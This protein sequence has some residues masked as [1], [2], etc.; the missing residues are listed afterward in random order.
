[1]IEIGLW[2]NWMALA[3]MTPALWAVSSI[4]DICF[5]GERIFRFPSDGPIISGLFGLL[6]LAVLGVQIG[7]WDT[8]P[9][10]SSAPAVLAGIC[11]FLHMYFVFKA[12]FLFNDGSCSEIF[13]LLSVLFVPFLAFLVLGEQLASMHYLAISLAFGGIMALIRGYVF[14]RN[15][16]VVL[17]LMMSVLC[18]SMAMVIQAWVF[19]QMPYWN[20][21]VLF[22]FGSLLTALML[23]C[24][25]PDRC[26]RI[27]TLCFRH[28]RVFLAVE[29]V[30]FTAVMFWQRAT[31]M[32]PSVS[33][34]AVLECSL[35]VFVMG[36]SFGLLAI[37]QRWK[38][39]TPVIREALRLQITA[40]PVK[41]LSLTLILS[42]IVM[43]H[44]TV[45]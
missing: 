24:W 40:T 18:I 3:M 37:S 38:T 6:P 30:E 7:G 14:D 10:L 28:G 32:S 33:F 2:D 21:V 15:R 31:A 45:P 43:V 5:V 22:S 34:V 19:T 35:P 17:L 4:I 39:G 42:A 1:M 12:L 11:Y 23:L 13:N 26:R 8:L 20:G 36:F 29:L 16:W 9:F 41:L 44:I 25:S 27:T